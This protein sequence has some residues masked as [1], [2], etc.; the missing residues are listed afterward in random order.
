MSAGTTTVATTGFSFLCKGELD[1]LRQRQVAHVQRVADR[2]IAEIDLDV[3]GQVIREARDV[4]LVQD[5]VHHAALLLHA[6]R[7]FGV[8]ESAAAPSC[9]SLVLRDAL[10]V[11]VLHCGLKGMH[12]ERAQQDLLLRARESSVRIDA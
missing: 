5:V 2:E 4:E 8:D 9:G 1:A 12:V 7:L 6:G 3:L 10:E 11:D